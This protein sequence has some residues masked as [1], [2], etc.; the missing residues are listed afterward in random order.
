MLL[1]IGQASFCPLAQANFEG[2]FPGQGSYEDWQKANLEYYQGVELQQDGKLDQAL[3]SFDLATKTYRYD[4]R[5]WNSLGICR[6]Q[7]KNQL[8]A[9][10][11]FRTAIGVNPTDK[12]SWLCLKNLLRLEGR[13]AEAKAVDARI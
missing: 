3:T 6:Q 2:A 7:G 5:Y 4:S 8:D 9:E 12:Q 1:V 11:A 13:D 10:Q